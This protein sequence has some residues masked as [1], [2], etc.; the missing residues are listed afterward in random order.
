MRRILL[1]ATVLGLL[2]ACAP[3]PVT[4]PANGV[5]RIIL[6]GQPEMLVEGAYC[7][8]YS[9]GSFGGGDLYI[10]CYHTVITDGRYMRR[11][12]DSLFLEGRLQVMWTVK[13]AT[14]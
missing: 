5:Y 2:T 4:R 9:P 7:F 10:A 3:T 6:E 13:E 1:A 12:R 8:S 14:P 11:D